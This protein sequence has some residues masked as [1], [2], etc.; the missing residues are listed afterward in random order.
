MAEEIITSPSQPTDRVIPPQPPEVSAWQQLGQ[1]TRSTRPRTLARTVLVLGAL[2]ALVWLANTA[3]QSLVPFVVG[4]FIA[5]AVL[6]FVNRL[7]RIMPRWLASLLVIVGVLIFI[8]LF[9]AT[10]VPLI[11][12]QVLILISRVPSANQLQ[13]SVAQVNQSLISL[14]EP[15]RVAIRQILTDLETSFRTQIDNFIFSL[16]QVTVRAALGIINTLSAVLGLLVLPTWLLIVLKDGKQGARE[17]NKLVPARARLD[18]WSIV[19]IVD[20]SLRAFLQQQ[21]TQAFLVGAGVALFAW[22]ID[23]ANLVDIKYPLAAGLIVGTLNLI[24]VIGSILAYI[25][26]VMAGLPQGAQVAVV[27]VG[28]FFLINKFAGQYVNARVATH[29]KQPH[30]A[31]MA[32]LAIMLSQ[33]GFV[34]AALSVPIIILSRDIFRYVY[35]RLNDPPRPAGLLP[36]DPRPIAPPDQQVLIKLRKPLVYQRVARRRPGQPP[37]PAPTDRT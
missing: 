13:Q 20:R 26:L 19:R 2:A 30:N 6:P 25:L 5:Y 24:P 31:V 1:R 9:I 8:A 34:Y 15:L 35:G 29:V 21:V 3:W 17:I 28:A 22:G 7:D 23:R 10:L 32:L 33:I 36:D 14:P 16:P 18:F 27:Y 37:T 11:L 4:G 12:N